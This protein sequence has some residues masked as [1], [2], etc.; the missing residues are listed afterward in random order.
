[1]TQNTTLLNDDF[2]DKILLLF[3]ICITPMVMISI[4]RAM[5][6]GWQTE[7]TF[8]ILILS[9]TYL[10]AVN[11]KVVPKPIRLF[12]VPSCFLIAGVISSANY[13]LV[14][15]GIS[16]MIFG[17]M[18]LFLIVNFKACIAIALLSILTMGT[19]GFLI[20]NNQINFGGDINDYAH[21]V[22]TWINTLAVLSILLVLLIYVTNNIK[23]SHKSI[24]MALDSK[25]R[26]LEQIKSS[27]G[28][29]ATIDKLT[30]IYNRRQFIELSNKELQRFKRHAEG[31]VLM[32]ISIDEFEFINNKYGYHEANAFLNFLINNI[33]NHIRQTDVLARW[34]G[35]ELALLMLETTVDHV[36][37]IAARFQ[38]SLS[39][40]FVHNEHTIK[41]SISIGIAPANETDASIHDIIKRVDMALHRAKKGGKDR[42]E[43]GLVSGSKAGTGEL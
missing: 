9:A 22:T 1:M 39:T 35:N 38:S 15:F 42:V 24:R 10:I 43:V 2:I 33:N 17:V 41:T 16:L 11:K 3:A 7:M 5:D 31:F 18:Y 26:E 19:I 36:K 37:D 25:A 34:S 13:G 14:G 4:Y 32:M 40:N 27:H 21:S 23:N 12:F 28:I 30:G 29:I 20:V 8:H 6:I